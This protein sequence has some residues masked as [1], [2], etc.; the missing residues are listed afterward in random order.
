MSDVN[1]DE[2]DAAQVVDTASI[3]NE[4]VPINAAMMPLEDTP[5]AVFTYGARP[6]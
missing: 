1:Q 6:P 3:S 2:V 4:D 5:R